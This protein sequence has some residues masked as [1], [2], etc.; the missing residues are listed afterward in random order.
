[1]IAARQYRVPI[2]EVLE[3]WSN[4]M[5]NV[6]KILVGVNVNSNPESS[7]V[8]INKAFWL[9]QSTKAEVTLCTVL[10]ES[11]PETGDFLEDD[12]KAVALR[13]AKETHDRWMEEGQQL[14]LTVHSI[15]R[16]GRAWYE[17]I[18]AVQSDGFDLVIVGTKERGAAH[19]ALFGSTAMKLLR[20]CPSMVWVCRPDADKPVATI[21]VADDCREVGMRAIQEGVSIAQMLDA[22]LLVVHAIQY[23][24]NSALRRV[25]T[26]QEELDEY[27]QR[28][29]D[30]AEK[31]V[32]ER[33]AGTD[34]RSLHQGA[35][36]EITA[37]PPDMVIDEAVRE[38]DAELLIMG[39]SGHSG[40]KGFLI[41]N[42]AERLLPQLRCSVLAIKPEGFESG[43]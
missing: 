3:Y 24:L 29:R 33:L 39:T 21:L 20:H 9:A 43:I 40:I 28:I 32:T 7:E 12:P 16:Y 23:P 42:T 5:Q 34:H 4:E 18:C 25:E 10:R 19:R 27:Q 15:V 31:A 41:G 36:I 17:M 30:E 11:P 26:S 6:R 14:G 35:R 37:G 8:A 22:R 38:H 13:I 1:M 2:H